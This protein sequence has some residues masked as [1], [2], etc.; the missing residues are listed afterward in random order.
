M[1][2]PD[3]LTGALHSASKAALV[4]TRFCVIGS[5]VEDGRYRCHHNGLG[6][7]DTDSQTI[8]APELL[9]LTDEKL[10]VVLGAWLVALHQRKAF[11]INEAK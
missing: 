11:A 4:C 3:A 1:L 5:S 8:F 10:A 6:S 9:A 7:S 2:T